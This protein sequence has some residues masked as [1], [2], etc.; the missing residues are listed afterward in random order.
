MHRYEELEQLYYKK[1]RN[2]IIFIS[3]VLALFGVIGYFGVTSIKQEQPQKE[4]KISVTKDK[5][6]SKQQTKP[7]VKPVKEANET[8]PK[9]SEKKEKPKPQQKE[10]IKP[11]QKEEAKPQTTSNESNETISLSFVLPNLDKIKEPK[12]KIKKKTTRV[13]KVKKTKPK[14]EKKTES[15]VKKTQ[16]TAP[17]EAQKANIQQL[18]SIYQK[19]PNFDLAMTISREYLKNNDLQKAREWAIKANTLNPDRPE[20]WLQFANIL[21]KEG[22]KQKAI[23]ILQVYLDSYGE[24]DMIEEKL[25]S[26]NE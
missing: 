22:K 13:K 20:S 19:N 9:V 3:I 12:I 25:R 10:E 2:R 15:V 26:L 5:N 24:N 23:K 7:D 18:E 14:K 4:Q 16:K 1:K 21:L 17:I 11:Q 6:E 8:K